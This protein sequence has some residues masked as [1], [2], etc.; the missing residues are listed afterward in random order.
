MTETQTKNPPGQPTLYNPDFHPED[1]IRLA[2]L[3]K[4]VA[5]CCADWGICRKTF[6][7]WAAANPEFLH[8]YAR[9]REI[10]NAFWID[11]AEQGVLERGDESGYTKTNQHVLKMLWGA[12]QISSDDRAIIIPGFAEAKT[13]ADKTRCVLDALGNGDI[14][15]NEADRFLSV[16]EKGLKIGEATELLERI[17][18]LEEA[19]GVEARN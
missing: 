16:L 17:A 1:L 2:M 7:N 8:A 13:D 6:Y 12:N 15:A 18:K 3:G 10:I 19:N 11:K 14:T 9:A 5:H 4:S